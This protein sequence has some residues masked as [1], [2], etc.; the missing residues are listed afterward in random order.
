MNHL[1]MEGDL[2]VWNIINPPNRP[3]TYPVNDPKHAIT[4]IDALA[5]S[6]L[7]D[8][9]IESNAFG[10]EVFDGAEWLEWESEEG[11]DIDEWAKNNLSEG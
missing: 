6:Q 5:Q 1:L 8:G 9:N 2:R 3:T 11:E 7:L 10:L 4:L